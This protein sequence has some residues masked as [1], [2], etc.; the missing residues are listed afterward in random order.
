MRGAIL[1]AGALL[2]GCAA[3]DPTGERIYGADH[4][5]PF[6][7]SGFSAFAASGP[8]VEVFGTPPGGASPEAVVA[9]LRLPG[10]WPQTPP[11]L[12][13]ADLPRDAQRIRL[14][15]GVMGTSDPV[16]VCRETPRGGATPG[17]VEL[18]AAYCRGRSGG[19]GAK[20]SIGRELAVDDPAFAQALTRLMGVVAPRR[21]PLDRGRGEG[22]RL[23][24]QR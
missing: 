5:T 21:D 1:V 9:A 20:L 7:I 8:V 14:V 16:G 18:Y 24:L 19:S 3:F 17:R 23:W 13:P 22:R 4:L 12:A 11:R 15:F 6:T 2:A 10:F